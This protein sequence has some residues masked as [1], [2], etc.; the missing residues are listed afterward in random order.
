METTK[1]K[2]I[3]IK[4]GTEDILET[5]ATMEVE[6]STDEANEILDSVEHSHDATIGINWDVLR[7]HIQ[8]FIDNKLN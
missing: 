3:S 6:I 7:C 2:T 5:A 4:W 8:E 1:R